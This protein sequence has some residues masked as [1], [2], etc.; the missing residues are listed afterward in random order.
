VARLGGRYKGSEQAKGGSR[1]GA[2]EDDD[3]DAMAK[4]YQGVSAR[5]TAAELQ[6]RQRQQ[7]IQVG[8]AAQCGRSPP[9]PSLPPTHT[10]THQT[11]KRH[12]GRDLLPIDAFKLPCA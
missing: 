8:W 9:P 7:A 11:Q 5:V 4:L 2:D 1:A 10:L 3:H 6:Q 12:T